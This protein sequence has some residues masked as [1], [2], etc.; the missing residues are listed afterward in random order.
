LLLGL[1]R[2]ID[3]RE[4]LEGVIPNSAQALRIWA[5]M[6]GVNLSGA[7]TADMLI[8]LGFEVVEAG[9][10]EEAL[11]LVKAGRTPDLL[12]T[13]HLMPGMNGAELAQEV[14][15][16]SPALPVLVVSGYAEVDG[17]A[18][19]LP[20]LTKPFRSAELEASVS[21]LMQAGRAAGS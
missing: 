16:L 12:V 5:A 9:S 6:A 3:S 15:Q 19:D 2:P 4:R 10:A 14:R 17:I 13:D 20:R 21:V 1:G 11:K 8:D 7:A 18:P